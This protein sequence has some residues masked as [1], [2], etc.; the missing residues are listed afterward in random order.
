MEGEEFKFAV[1][2]YPIREFW[3]LVNAIERPYR[4]K[5]TRKARKAYCAELKA[6]WVLLKADWVLLKYRTRSAH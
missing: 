4:P 6:D 3:Q 2:A 5:G 1:K